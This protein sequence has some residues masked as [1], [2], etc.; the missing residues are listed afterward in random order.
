MDAQLSQGWGL[1]DRAVWPCSPAAASCAVAMRHIV[2]TPVMG[3][4]SLV[5]KSRLPSLPA[6][7]SGAAWVMRQ[8]HAVAAAVPACA[9]E[10]EQSHGLVL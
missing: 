8:P 10:A 7:S 4:P 2:F 1:T 6:R 3:S 9:A 5:R